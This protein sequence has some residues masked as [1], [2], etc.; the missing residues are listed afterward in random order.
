MVSLWLSV[1]SAMALNLS[2]TW[3]HIPGRIQSSG[4]LPVQCII[5]NIS[6]FITLMI[7]K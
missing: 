7:G 1:C 2:N 6:C 4:P 5:L 3:V